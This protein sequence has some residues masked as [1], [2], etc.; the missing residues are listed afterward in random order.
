MRSLRWAKSA[1]RILKLRGAAL[2]RALDNS[3]GKITLSGQGNECANP[4]FLLAPALG[5]IGI[6]GDAPSAR[7][8]PPR[9]AG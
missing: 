6:A 4:L 5:G 7:P 2:Q 3:L 1:H 9:P 8:L